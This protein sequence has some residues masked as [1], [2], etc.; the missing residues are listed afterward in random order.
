MLDVYNPMYYI[1]HRVFCA[2]L[3]ISIFSIW[4]A[5]IDLGCIS[6]QQK[7]W[8]DYKYG[9][10]YNFTDIFYSIKF[11]KKYNNAI[12]IKVC[13]GLFVEQYIAYVVSIL[14][15]AS[16]AHHMPYCIGAR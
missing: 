14:G 3:Y 13:L 11:K 9:Q 16:A 6:K 8:E 5:A 12:T 15:Y 4:G 2:L 1:D 7:L 10:P